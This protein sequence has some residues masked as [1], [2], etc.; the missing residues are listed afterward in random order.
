MSK[1]EKNTHTIVTASET[2]LQ[3]RLAHLNGTFKAKTKN[4]CMKCG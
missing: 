3:K 1:H 2:V 4:A